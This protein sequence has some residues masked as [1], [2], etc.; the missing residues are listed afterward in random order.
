MVVWLVREGSNHA[1]AGIW[2]EG[3]DLKSISA[4]V[5]R[6]ETGKRQYALFAGLAANNGASAA[7]VSENGGASFGDKYARNLST[8]SELIPTIPADSPAEE[9]DRAWSVVAFSFDN[10]RNT[11]TSYLNGKATDYWIEEP[12][13]HPF[14]QWPARAWLQAELGRQPGMQQGEDAQFPPNQ[15]YTP[16]E[17]KPRK[18]ELVKQSTEER[19][20][21]HHYEFTRVRTTLG[22]DQ[23]GRF[24]RVLRRELAALRVNPFWFGHDLYHPRTPQEGGPFTIGEVVH[25]SR[26]QGFMGYLGGVAVFDRPLSARQMARLAAIGRENGQLKPIL[27][28]DLLGTARPQ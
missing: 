19:I 27:L 21:L 28:R 16:P 11:V 9:I 15:H 6:V 10:A 7:H 4:S 1:I 2:H 12:E 20:E 14:F 18:V 24:R 25:T 5:Q 23:R 8:T 26:S 22:K 3:T 13:Q 17:R